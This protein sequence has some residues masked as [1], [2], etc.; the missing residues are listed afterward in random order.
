MKKIFLIIALLISSNLFSQTN[1]LDKVI[2]IVGKNMIKL[3]E[4]ET[5]FLQQRQQTGIVEN[6]F[7]VKCDILEGLLINKLMLHQAEIDSI[8]VTDEQ[9][10]RELDRRLML[11]MR[12]AG[13]KEELERQMNKSV[14]E[15]K[16]YYKDIIR[17]NLLIN[18]VN[19][20]LTTD[21]KITPKEV[22][23]YYND[24]PKDSLPIVEQEYEFKQIVLTPQISNEEKEIIKERLNGYRDRILKG[25]KFS[26]L[27]ALYS[28]DPGSAKK[29]GEL[30]FFTRGFM[31]GEFEAVAFSLREGEISPVFETKY[32]FHIV[33]LI[34]RRGDQINCRHIL[35]QP[36]V[37]DKE[38]LRTKKKLDS[39]YNEIKENKISF[40]DAIKQFSDDDSK[41][42]GG[43]IVNPYN[44][45]ARFQK[46]NINQVMENLDKI[47]F[48][49]YNQGD[50]I[51]SSLFKTEN[52]KAYRLIKVVLKTPKHKVNLKDDYDKVYTSALENAK[53]NALLLWANKTIEKTYIKLDSSYNDCSFKLNWIKK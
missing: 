6:A 42:T 34:E 43:L 18:E 1:T 31:V 49:K 22:E 30:G 12:Q 35:L 45:S 51:P 33:Q 8:K 2:A 53:T 19:Q 38:L 15:L 41:Q 27:A 48:E 37:S 20:K 40:E 39:I 36:Q 3:S 29:G 4:L 10:E 13:S 50:I 25:D 23:E 24:I 46:E 47:D 16:E 11:M 9:V 14:N 44:A 28:E 17:E 7:D 52:S 5:S 21:V 26:T 32:G